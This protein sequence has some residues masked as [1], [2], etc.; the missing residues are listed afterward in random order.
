MKTSNQT[1][2]RMP[3]EWET[4]DSTWFTWPHNEETFPEHLFAAQKTIAKC[5]REIVKPRNQ[6]VQERADVI[7]RNAEEATK[8]KSILEF[9][10]TDLTQVK[11]HCIPNNDVWIRDYG[12]IFVSCETQD[13]TSALA[14]I[15]FQFDA[16]GGKSEDYYGATA[17]LDDQIGLA[18][19]NALGVR[20]IS[21]NAVL[22]G[23]A[24]ETN[25]QG[26]CI[27]TR[28]C[29]IQR[30]NKTDEAEWERIFF[31]SLGIDQVLWLDGVQF[32]GDDTEGHID[33]LTRFVGP[34]EVL[35]LV[36]ENA[37]DP[38]YDALQRNLNQLREFRTKEGFP[39]E[40]TQMLMP[41]PLYMTAIMD[42]QRGRRRY[43]ASYANYIIGN[44]VVLV[45]TFADKNDLQALDTIA[46]CF[47]ERDVIGID[48]SE[49]ILGQGALHCSTQQ[50]PA[51]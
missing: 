34:T 11:F 14:G 20:S 31:E 37:N 23:G 7:V 9:F 40:I 35:T 28:N 1:K 6:L 16:W 36:S 4:H 51:L 39:L 15:C 18:I 25:G 2:I 32:D 42:G 50:Q 19:C 24:I 30:D 13:N 43:P 45:P 46:A 29:L 38:W 47:P 27:T 3:A 49:Y 48:C 33:N 22:E 12:P 17:K 26:T 5:I 8:A 21:V 10:G 44:G 41:S